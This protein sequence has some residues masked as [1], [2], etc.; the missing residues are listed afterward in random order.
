MTILANVERGALLL[1]DNMP[2]WADKIDLDRLNIAVGSLC[3]LG[4][5]FSPEVEEDWMGFSQ[6]M[7]R[8]LGDENDT[9]AEAVYHGFDGEPGD[10]HGLT[11]AW[12]CEIINR[13]P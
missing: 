8:L 5:L 4:Q 7:T 3:I 6:G 10:Y 13:L 11:L 2:G 1:D 12:E 9:Y